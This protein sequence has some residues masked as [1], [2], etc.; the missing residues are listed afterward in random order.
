[1]SGPVKSW[2]SGSS[3]HPPRM[4]VWRLAS[5]TRGRGLDGGAGTPACP[6]VES[7]LVPKAVGVGGADLQFR[8]RSGSAREGRQGRGTKLAGERPVRTLSL[9]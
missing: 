6:A 7:A 9:I 5:R 4:Q 1:M 2:G 3:E 8:R